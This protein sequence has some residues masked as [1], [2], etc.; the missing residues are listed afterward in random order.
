MTPAEL[1]E[2]EHA[3]EL[4]EP[5]G[6]HIAIFSKRARELIAA[7]KE[8]DEMREMLRELEWVVDAQDDIVCPRCGAM[9][10]RR[11]Y[12]DTVTD[13]KGNSVLVA[14]IIGEHEPD[15]KLAKVLGR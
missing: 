15:C 5:V 14:K 13:Y 8:R 1:E 2:L 10:E 6:D 12:S 7:Y 3:A 4:C 9:R 11:E